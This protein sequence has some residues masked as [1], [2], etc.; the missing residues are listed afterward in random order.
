[1]LSIVICREI[2]CTH[3]GRNDLYNGLV[4]DLAGRPPRCLENCPIEDRA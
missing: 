1:M 2:H 3:L 4:C